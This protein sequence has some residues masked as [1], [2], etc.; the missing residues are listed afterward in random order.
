M[1]STCNH[2]KKEID[3]ESYIT[4]QVFNQCTVICRLR[5]LSQSADV[6]S[7]SDHRD[8]SFELPQCRSYVRAH[9][10]F[11]LKVACCFFRRLRGDMVF[12][13]SKSAYL[14]DEGDH[15]I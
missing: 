15:N 2:M 1:H 6:P 3:L 12:M 10:G 14:Y 5:R 8:I 4:R 7:A 9:E 11:V 13:T